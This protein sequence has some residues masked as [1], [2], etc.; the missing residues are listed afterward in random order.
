[1]PRSMILAV[2][3]LG[4]A[5]SL[6]LAADMVPTPGSNVRFPTP[7]DVTLNGKP[8]KFVLTGTAL[9]SKYF[10]SVYAIGGYVQEGSG[11]KSPED[12]ASFDGFKRLELVMER[13]V[14]GKDM[15]DAF[16]SAIRL[17]YPV[18]SYNAEMAQLNEAVRALNLTRGDHV[19]LTH[20]P[21]VGLHVALAGKSEMIIR[22]PAFTKA[23]W[24]IYLGRTNLGNEIKRG[25]VSRL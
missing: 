16:Q 9:R 18:P 22:N 10:V 25:L 24:D 6:A 15:A 7:V 8:V 13:D 21:G 23:V 4:V 14:S 1:M 17:N 5:A 12:L 2:T 19:W 20:L 3:L 11:V